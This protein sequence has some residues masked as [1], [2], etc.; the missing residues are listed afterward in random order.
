MI[1]MWYNVNSG[2]TTHSAGQKKPNGYGLYDMSGNVWEWCED[3]YGENYYQ[4]S[5]E[6]N[7]K[8]PDT[9]YTRV[10]RGGSWNNNANNCRSAYRLGVDPSYWGNYLGFRAVVSLK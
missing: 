6:S 9:N 7:P 8:G 10:L 2:N 5:P 1:I 3:W 4:S